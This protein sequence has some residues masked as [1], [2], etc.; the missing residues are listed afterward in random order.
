MNQNTNEDYEGLYNVSLLW[1]SLALWIEWCTSTKYRFN[2]DEDMSEISKQL[3][4]YKLLASGTTHGELLERVY[5]SNSF[6]ANYVTTVFNATVKY[7][8]FRLRYYEISD[9]IELKQ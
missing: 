2:L 5:L 7:I 9:H 3:S 4:D 1:L 8:F 6:Y